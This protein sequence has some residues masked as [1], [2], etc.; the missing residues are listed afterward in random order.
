MARRSKLT[1]NSDEA[2]IASVL[3]G[4][5]IFS[6]PYF[7][8]PYKWKPERI[9]RLQEDILNV[10]DN[11]IDDTPDSHFLGAIIIHGR[12]RNPSEPTVFEVI[13]GQQ[14][15]TTIFIFIAAIVCTLC[16]LKQYDEA[17]GL[18]QR[19]LSLGRQTGMLSN[20]KPSSWKRR[21]KTI[22]FYDDRF[23]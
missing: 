1:N 8:R 21:P 15:L 2:E 18:F 22:Q 16:K 14:R 7:Q 9:R 12:R 20:V 3:S 17:I 19:Y 6:I 10:V 4:D 23:D 13:D 5:S 11:L